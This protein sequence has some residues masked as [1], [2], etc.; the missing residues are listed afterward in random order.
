[1]RRGMEPDRICQRC[2][3]LLGNPADASPTLLC[4]CPFFPGVKP[5]P[6]EDM[7]PSED[8]DYYDP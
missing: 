1:M 6:D 4:D 3:G 7:D 5:Y 2:G 8:P